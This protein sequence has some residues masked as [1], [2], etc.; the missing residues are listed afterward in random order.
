MKKN[1]LSGRE[2]AGF[3]ALGPACSAWLDTVANVRIHGE[4]RERPV[5]LL[6]VERQMLLPLGELTTA[7]CRTYSVKVC[8]R[9]RVN[10]EGNRYSVPPAYVRR[11]LTLQLGD[12]HLEL[13]DGDRLVARHRH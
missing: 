7:T 6:K 10:V 11:T 1:F 4:T 8:P 13:Y 2:E 9:C 3:E 5:D 12:A